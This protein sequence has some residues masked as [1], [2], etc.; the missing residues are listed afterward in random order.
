MKNTEKLIVKKSTDNKDIY[1]NKIM[2]FSGTKEEAKAFAAQKNFSGVELLEM[3][4]KK[5]KYTT[6]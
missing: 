5:V 6:L 2:N 1:F 4:G 3:N